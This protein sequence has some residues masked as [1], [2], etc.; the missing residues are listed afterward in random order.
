[1]NITPRF[2]APENWPLVDPKDD[3]IRPA[4]KPDECFYCNSKVGKP[5]GHDCVCV[6]KK[7]RVLYTIE[8]VIEVPHSHDADEIIAF[9][10]HD[11][12]WWSTIE[13]I[14]AGYGN[15]ELIGGSAAFIRTEDDTPRRELRDDQGETQ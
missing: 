7:V 4:G 6:K 5:H 10:N 14:A 3:G 8:A 2:Q 9:E 11:G 12:V 13:Q 15:A 1:M